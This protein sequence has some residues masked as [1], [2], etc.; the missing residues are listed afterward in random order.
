[1]VELATLIGMQLGLGALAAAVIALLPFDAGPT[2][3]IGGL[4]VMLGAQSFAMMREHRAPGDVA[5]KA[6]A[7]AIG[8][9]C[10]HL[11]LGALVVLVIA[12][13][14]GAPREVDRATLGWLIPLVVVVGTALVFALTLWG[15]RTGVRTVARSRDR[16]RRDQGSR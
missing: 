8:A 16:A 3:W 10:G 1:M 15:L 13:T 5:G 6:R 14:D 2:S 12:V 9:A 4:G 7:L 11:A